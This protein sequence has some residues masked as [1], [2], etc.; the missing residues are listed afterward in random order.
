MVIKPEEQDCNHQTKVSINTLVQWSPRV[1]AVPCCNQSQ[2]LDLANAPTHHLWACSANSA[3]TSGGIIFR[4]PIPYESFRGAL[5]HALSINKPSR[6]EGA[7]H[8]SVAAISR[9]NNDAR[10]RKFTQIRFMASI[11]LRPRIYQSIPNTIVQ[12]PFSR[13]SSSI[14]SRR[15]R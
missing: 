7:Q 13:T 11:P 2:N 4:P 5:D 14:E 15:E 8:L 6:A 9:K 12:L 1:R 3:A 10:V